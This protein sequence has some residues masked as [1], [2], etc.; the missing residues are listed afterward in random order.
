MKIKY[1][2]LTFLILLVGCISSQKEALYVE[3]EFPVDIEVVFEAKI[4]AGSIDFLHLIYKVHDRYPCIRIMDFNTEIAGDVSAKHYRLDKYWGKEWQAIHKINGSYIAILDHAIE[5]AGSEFYIIQINS[6]GVISEIGVIIKKN[7]HEEIYIESFF[8]NGIL[9]VVTEYEGIQKT[10]KLKI[11]AS[12]FSRH[13]V[14]ESKLSFP[15][16]G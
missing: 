15:A 2:I 5:C 9:F 13:R 4:Q 1:C 3:K 8:D 14:S 11:G 7:G 10:Y 16:C 12:G 6:A